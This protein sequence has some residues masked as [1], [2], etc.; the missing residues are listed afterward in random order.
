MTRASSG[1]DLHTPLTDDCDE[2]VHAFET[3]VEVTDVGSI[4]LD[5]VGTITT[6]NERFCELVGH[7]EQAIVGAAFTQFLGDAA[8][9]FQ[10]IYNQ[11][12]AGDPSTEHVSTTLSNAT[13]GAVECDLHLQSLSGDPMSET[14]LVIVD[15]T[16]DS[17]D[18][19]AEPPASR[20]QIEDLERYKTILETIHDGVYV[21]N[22]DYEFEMVNDGYA[23]MVGYD[24]DDLIGEHISTVVDEDIVETGEELRRE[25]HTGDRET[26]TVEINLQCKGGEKITVETRF[27]RLPTDDGSFKGTVGVVRNF[28]DRTTHVQTLERRVRQQRAIA[29]FGQKALRTRDTAELL[30]AATNV[31][32]D[33]LGVEFTKVLDLNADASELQLRAG[34]GWDDGLVGEA[35]VKTNTASQAGYTLLSEEPVVVEDFATETR[36][37]APPLLE[38]HDVESGISVIIGDY[39]NPWG[40]FGAHS[41]TPREFTEQDVSFVRSIANVLATAISRAARERERERY[42]TIVETIWD[43]VY[44][45]DGDDNFVMVNDAFCEMTGYSREELLGSS[46]TLV[47]NETIQET[48]RGMAAEM[49]GGDREAATIELDLQKKDGTTIPAESRFGPYPYANDSD[50]RAGVV[51]DITDRRE[52]ERQVEMLNDLNEVVREITH[53]LVESNARTDIEKLVCERFGTADLYDFAWLGSVADDGTTVETVAET[54]VSDYLAAVPITTADSETRDH[55]LNRALRTR[56]TVFATDVLADDD[57]A[58]WHDDAR[59]RGYRSVAAIPLTYQNISYGVLTIYSA[60]ADAFGEHEQR[61]LSQVG[62]VIGH[63]I[64]AIERKEA[65]MADRITEVTF[66]TNDLPDALYALHG[67]MGE[68]TIDRVVPLNDGTVLKYHSVREMSPDAYRDA[69]ENVPWVTDVR[70]IN[71]SPD[72]TRFEVVT[73][74]PTASSTLAT[75]GGRLH[76]ITLTHDS[77]EIEAELPASVDLRQVSE[78]LYE[79]YPGL[80]L[81][82]R[83]TIDRKVAMPEELAESLIG[84]LT[85]RQRTALKSAYYSGFFDWPRESAGTDVAASLDVSPA[86]F[87]EHLRRAQR[88]IFTTLFEVSPTAD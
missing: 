50:G 71:T 53:A 7:E 79:R 38:D 51:R 76:S 54:G 34:I 62:D 43:G 18:D 26:G 46:A 14:V 61:I 31:V 67:E 16:P 13:G 12:N 81:V 25:L 59:E 1:D 77:V 19:P 6:A 22:E 4:T 56:E 39:E 5:G 49:R 33:G 86:T 40:V 37:T 58:P 85:E 78:A 29:D 35:T 15:P 83:N 27:A 65:L 3:V 69:L 21:A 70:E 48:A 8:V 2:A 45:L 72:V 44:A 66:R 41:T 20:A 68:V 36:F 10:S 82:S 17:T 23:S 32:S 28:E 88:K 42:E 87:H 73:E 47:H 11:L 52:W 64:N 75:Y 84:Q 55:P 24:R 80:E 74:E 30:Q 60:R 57:Y 63:A 9:S